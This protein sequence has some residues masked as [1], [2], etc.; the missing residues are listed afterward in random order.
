V[1]LAQRILLAISLVVVVATVALSLAVQRAWER[2]AVQQFSKDFGAAT[3]RLHEQLENEVTQLPRQLQPLCEHGQM[4]DSTLTALEA[5]RL[6]RE[7]KYAL[8]LLVPATKRGFN[9]DALMLL[10][11]SGEVLG[12]DQPARVGTTDPQLARFVNQ[13]SSAE[14]RRTETGWAIEASCNK[15]G[16]QRAVGLVATKSLQAIF[17]RVGATHGLSLSHVRPSDRPA[18]FVKTIDVPALGDAP[19]FATPKHLRIDEAVAKLN[20]QILQWGAL[21]LVIALGL[22]FWF[23]R[24][25]AQPIVSMSEQARRVVEGSVE[26]I[27]ATGGREL[28]E[29]A[30]SFNKTIEDLARLRRRLAATERVAAQREIA[31]RVAHEIK[32][33]LAP[34]R[35]AMETLRRLRRRQDPAFDEYF[36]EATQTVLD[37]VQRIATIVREFTEFARLPPPR[38]DWFDFDQMLGGVVTLHQSETTRIEVRSP[39]QTDVR[40]DRDQCVQVVTN[41]LQNA[42]DAVRSRTNPHVRLTLSII[43]DQVQLCI[44]DNGPG[45]SP[46]VAESV[47]KPYVTT[48][49]EGTGLG[50]AI[51]Q[52]IVIEHGGEVSVASS[53]MGGAEFCVRLPVDGPAPASETGP[54]SATGGSE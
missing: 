16:K 18:P 6:D 3:S 23:A 36:N 1:S 24:R 29:F 25:L 49:H 46:D 35:A 52:R 34:I 17:E 10:T 51:V 31:R 32:N 21:V 38:P 12:A 7:R 33:P 50:L 45:L 15:R 11:D 47:F 4:V 28:R 9:F 54:P 14:L 48:K 26:P 37:E 39:G 43:S 19:I 30:D 27:R 41:L 40:A 20:H 5:G 13:P 22:G 42:L 44:A 8:S 2:T 53:D